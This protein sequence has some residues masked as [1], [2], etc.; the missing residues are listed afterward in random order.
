MKYCLSVLLALVTACA[1]PPPEK[2]LDIELRNRASHPVEIRASTGLLQRT[3][4]LE[5]GEVWHGWV[6]RDFAGRDV[7]IEVRDPE[8]E[9]EE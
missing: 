3:L 4:T 2:R 7:R 9:K 8:S 5:P 1:I 6:L